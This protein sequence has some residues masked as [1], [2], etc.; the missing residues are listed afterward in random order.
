MAAQIGA[1]DVRAI[2]AL[3]DDDAFLVDD[4]DDTAGWKPRQ[5]ERVLEVLQLGADRQHRADAAGL[6]LD[7]SRQRNHPSAVDAGAKHFADCPLLSRHGLLEIAAVA[8]VD[9]IDGRGQADIGAVGSKQQKVCNDGRHLALDLAQDGVVPGG[10]GLV[11]GDG[12]AHPDQEALEVADV[13]IDADRDQ[14][15]FVECALDCGGLVMAPLIPQAHA[16][17]RRERNHGRDHEPQHSRSNAAQQHRHAPRVDQSRVVEVVRFHRVQR[18]TSETNFL[19]RL[20]RN[21]TK[22]VTA[23]CNLG[24]VKEMTIQLEGGARRP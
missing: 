2:V 11:P 24:E 19:D 22:C 15:G 14:A 13:V 8:A 6:V 16:D 20:N 23:A 10:V 12:A 4:A 9:A 3:S 17:Q 7:R 18:H 1:D 21:L 5:A